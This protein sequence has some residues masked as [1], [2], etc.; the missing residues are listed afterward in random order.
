M[1]FPKL[2]VDIYQTQELTS[3]APPSNLLAWATD[4]TQN[5]LQMKA[6]SCIRRHQEQ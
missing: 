5:Y 4:S 1:L 2:S 3:E 6:V